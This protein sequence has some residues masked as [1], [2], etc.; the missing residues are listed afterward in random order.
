MAFLVALFVI[1]PAYAAQVHSI[2]W[3]A[4]MQQENEKAAT[5]RSSA[6]SGGAVPLG[7]LGKDILATDQAFV[8]FWVE[9]EYQSQPV[10]ISSIENH[11]TYT[12]SRF[13]LN[14]G[15]VV[16]VC[17]M[18]PRDEITQKISY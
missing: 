5:E 10:G 14:N 4:N 8:R 3:K 16:Q 12:V 13:R 7:K 6:I 1:N 18:L 17:T 15:K 11:Q 9:Q 2:V